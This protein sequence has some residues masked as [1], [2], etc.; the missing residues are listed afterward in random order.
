MMVDY[1]NGDNHFLGRGFN[2]EEY[3]DIVDKWWL[4]DD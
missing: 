4:L 1:F 3:K 2:Y